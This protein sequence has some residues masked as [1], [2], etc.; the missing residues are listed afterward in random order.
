MYAYVLNTLFLLALETFKV[1][2]ILMFSTL[3]TEISFVCQHLFELKSVNLTLKISGWNI[4]MYVSVF[5]PDKYMLLWFVTKG[6][7]IYIK[8]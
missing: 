5:T 6:A 7:Y 1:L 3:H 8:F 4:N 2:Y